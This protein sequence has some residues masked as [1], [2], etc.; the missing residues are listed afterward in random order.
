MELLILFFPALWWVGSGESYFT[1]L[2]NLNRVKLYRHNSY[3]KFVNVLS[4]ENNSSENN[5]LSSALFNLIIVALSVIALLFVLDIWLVNREES[6][7]GV[8]G[9]F[10][11]G[12]LNPILTFLTFLGLIVTIVVQRHDL[13]LSRVEY[14]K[15]SQALTVQSVENSFFN[16]LEL[17]NKI[18][19]NL[20][21]D[22]SSLS[23]SAYLERLSNISKYLKALNVGRE[24]S[25]YV[26]RI[27]SNDMKGE[28]ISSIGT[29]T[30]FEGRAAFHE[31]LKYLTN[32][33]ATPKQIFSRYMQIQTEHN[34]IVGHY[35]RNLYQILKMID[36][37][38]DSVVSVEN[39]FKYAS[40]LRAQLSTKELALLFINCLDNVCDKGQFKNYLIKYQMFEHLQCKEDAKIKG[41]FQL[42]GSTGITVDRSMLL[43]YRKEKEFPPLDLDKVYGGAFGK[44][45]GVP[46][47]L[48][49]KDYNPTNAN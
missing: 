47:N 1:C 16:T 4:E 36:R 18:V 27:G 19:D 29:V 49:R 5:L 37:Y 21:F 44:N 42:G 13:R 48:A 46:H 22:L 15:T 14:E 12:V 41:H 31:I 25:E 10:F 40:L 9:D 33:A 32:G 43:Q 45:R 38:D 11:G 26:R 2:Q 8:F 7:A 34:H 3:S 39:K 6:V 30:V 35:F 24:G 28:A 17:H 20:K 23:G